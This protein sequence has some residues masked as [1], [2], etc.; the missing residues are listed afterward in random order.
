MIFDVGPVQLVE[1]GVE[2]GRLARAGRPGH[3][4]DPVGPLDQLLEPLPVLVAEPQVLEP[5]LDVVPVQ[6]PHDD[7]LTMRGWD[8]ADTQVD[9]LAGDE[10]LDPAVLGA[11][12]LG[13]VDRAHDLEAADDRAEEA[14]RVRCR[15][16]CS[17]PSIR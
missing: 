6:D 12:F 9:V 10:D 4:Q 2:R 16:P 15:A 17:T 3:Q 8:D 5:D 13:D 11:A 7:R 1:R 14:A